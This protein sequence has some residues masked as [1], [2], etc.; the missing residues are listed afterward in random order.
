MCIRDSLTAGAKKVIISAPAKGDVFTVVLG[1]NEDQYNPANDHVLSNAS[2]T[3]NCLA[4]MVKVLHD[5]FN[6]E[7]GLMSTIHSYTGD[8]QILDR[9]HSDMRRAR[10]AAMNII[11]TS[12]GAAK[13]VSVAIPALQGKIHGMA[14]RVP[15]STVS[16]IALVA[17]L[18]RETTTEEVNS[19]FQEAAEGKL[20]GILRYSDEPLV[21]S[22]FKEDPHSCIFDAP[23]TMVMGGTMIKVVGWYDNEWGYSCRT[24][25]LCAFLANRGL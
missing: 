19:A 2:C 10:S 1:V 23:L 11:P 20:Q 18:D 5:T 24:A 22:D 16:E 8:Q 4:T 14:F 7:H 17:V 12:T 15:T 9:S 13:A 6:V 21:S 3:T 25:D